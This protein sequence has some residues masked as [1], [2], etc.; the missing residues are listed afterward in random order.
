MESR[1][2]K[3]FHLCIYCNSFSG[4]FPAF[5]VDRTFSLK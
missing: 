3:A 2:S 4:F 5:D 1:L